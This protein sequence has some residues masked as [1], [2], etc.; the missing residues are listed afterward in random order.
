M[1]SSKVEADVKLAHQKE[2]H[3]LPEPRVATKGDFQG[4]FAG[5]QQD[6]CVR[7]CQDGKEVRL[8]APPVWSYCKSMLA[9]SFEVWSRSISV[10]LN[11]HLPRSA[12]SGLSTQKQRKWNTV[13]EGAGN[14]ADNHAHREKLRPFMTHACN[15]FHDLGRKFTLI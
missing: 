3:W 10:F 15:C 2:F 12:A 4:R 11:A 5:S 6:T 1:Q 14:D 9:M 13:E 8:H 7:Y